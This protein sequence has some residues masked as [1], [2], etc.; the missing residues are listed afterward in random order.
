MI[1]HDMTDAV[2]LRCFEGCEGAHLRVI[3]DLIGDCESLMNR[4]T[5]AGST[6]GA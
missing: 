6:V 4:R 5:Y 1:H 2:I 3:R